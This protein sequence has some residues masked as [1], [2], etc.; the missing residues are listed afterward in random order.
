MTARRR[1]VA[2][3]T[4]ALCAWATFGVAPDAHSGPPAHRPGS[5]HDPRSIERPRA[6]PAVVAS[7]A[8]VSRSDRAPRPLPPIVAGALTCVALAMAWTARVRRRAGS[9][10]RAWT[11]AFDR[12]GPPV[13]LRPAP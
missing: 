4:I 6:H 5:S 12:R 10:R 8:A 7:S 2:L 11:F 1:F 3:A 9:V 13:L